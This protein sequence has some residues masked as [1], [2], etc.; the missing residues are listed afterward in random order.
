MNGNIPDTFW[1]IEEE[2]ALFGGACLLGIPTGI[3]F[4]MGRLF[5]RVIPHHHRLTIAIEDILWMILVAVLLL[6][7]ASG[8]AKGVFRAYYAVGCLL[9]FI[10][11]ECTLGQPTVTLLYKV[12]VKPFTGIARIYTKGW[13]RFVQSTKKYL[14]KKVFIQNCLQHQD[15]KVYNRN[16]RELKRKRKRGDNYGE[17][18]KT[19]GQ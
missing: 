1:T 10:L 4:D 16:S 13:Q 12:F 6:C 19:S 17:E 15:K 7:Y 8:F 18:N 14:P 5:R 3:L 9:G 11:Y 2:L